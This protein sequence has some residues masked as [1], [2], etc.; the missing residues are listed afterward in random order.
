M[1]LN[2]SFQS[3]GDAF[4]VFRIMKPFPVVP[5]ECF[6]DPNDSV[7][8][9]TIFQQIRGYISAMAAFKL[10]YFFNKWNNVLLKIIERFNL[11]IY[12]FRMPVIISN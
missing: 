12:I 9:A 2:R 5:E 4:G 10:T 3:F 8:S 1:I 6:A 7:G 11:A